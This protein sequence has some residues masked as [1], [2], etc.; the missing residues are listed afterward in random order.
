MIAGTEVATDAMDLVAVEELG[1]ITTKAG[2]TM[3]ILARMTTKETSESAAGMDLPEGEDGPD[4]EERKLDYFWMMSDMENEHTDLLFAKGEY[5]GKT[6]TTYQNW[7]QF[8][9][10][11]YGKTVLKRN[12]ELDIFEEDD[13]KAALSKF[14]DWVKANKKELQLFGP[15]EFVSEEGMAPLGYLVYTSE[16][17]MHFFLPGLE[18]FRV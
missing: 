6:L 4:E 17:F 7:V 12:A 5:K 13:L 9:F 18:H 8:Y 14:A 1:T 11:P 3:P 10:K 16:A 2:E 15:M